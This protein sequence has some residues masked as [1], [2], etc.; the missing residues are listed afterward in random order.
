[1]VTFEGQVCV[2]LMRSSSDS[3]P[4]GVGPAGMTLG[5]VSVETM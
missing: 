4:D 5:G 1:M 3:G 2:V